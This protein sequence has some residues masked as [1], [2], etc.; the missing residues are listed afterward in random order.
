MSAS[1]TSLT[2]R[3]L[4]RRCLNTSSRLEEIT[5]TIPGVV[6]Q[7]YARPDGTMG[8]YYVS[9]LAPEVFGIS[10]NTSDFF[11]RFTSQVDPRDRETLLNSINEAV[12]QRSLFNFEGRFIK[13]SGETIWFQGIS[14]PF[15]R[16]TEIVFSGVLLDIT[17]RKQTEE[18]LQE[19]EQNYRGVIENLQDVF[20]RAD[21]AGNITMASPSAKDVFGYSSVDEVIGLNLARDFY[22]DPKNRRDFLTAIQ[23]TGS[24]KNFE[25]ILKKKD[26]SPVIVSTSAH[27]YHDPDGNVLGVEG[28]AKDITEWKHAEE[29]LRESE[30]KFRAIIDQSFQFIGLMN[31]DGTLIE[32]NRSALAFAGISESDVINR[33]FWETPWWSHSADLQE[34]L[35]DAIQRAASGETVRFEATHPAA[36]GHLAYIDFSIKPMVDTTGRILYLIPEGRDIT[37]R[38]QAEEKLSTAYGQLSATEEELRQQYEELAQKEEK[39]RVSEEKFR[40]LVES[41]SDFIWEVDERGTYTY[42]SPQVRELLGTNRKSLSAR[43]PLT[44]CNR[45]RRGGWPR[46]FPDLSSPGCRYHPLRTAVSTRTGRSL[47]LRQA[48]C[49]GWQKTDLLP[50]TAVLTVTS[51]CAST[52]KRRYGTVK[53]RSGRRAQCWR[54]CSMQ[55]RM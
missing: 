30:E 39:L 17:D 42:V 26:G 46:S 3:R 12:R 22:T 14:R 24:V 19:S 21:A 44:S 34:M 20:Y 48:A 40:A 31:T 28:I 32:A 47:S 49:P 6:Y 37:E 33:P 41:T 10:S 11:E 35:K 9:S 27:Y 5:G 53:Q 51:L 38:K 1:G 29:A 50:G 52:L 8:L 7:F 43:S 45:T 36:D 18:A 4:K 23:K 16:G 13:P 25:A 2:G 54:H 55:F 15:T